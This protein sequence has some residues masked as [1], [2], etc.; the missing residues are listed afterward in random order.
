ML[1]LG[2]ASD[3]DSG[4]YLGATVNQLGVLSPSV[5]TSCNLTS[6]GHNYT[7]ALLHM[8]RECPPAGTAQVPERL[9]TISSPVNV[10]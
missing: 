10:Q 8:E 7:E 3:F 6:C 5:Q 1:G 4:Y 9:A 2:N